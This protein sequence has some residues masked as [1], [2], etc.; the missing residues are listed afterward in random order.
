MK[1]IKRM[2]QV[3]F[4][5]YV[6]SHLLKNGIKVVLSGGASVSFYSNNAYVSHDL[7]LINV[8]FVKRQ[9]I[10]NSLGGLGFTEHGRHFIH[11][12]TKFIVEFPDGPLSV[13]EEPVKEIVEFEFSTGTLRVISATDCV[14]DRL[15]AYY[16]W[17]DNQGLA[18]AVLVAKSY[19]VDLKEIE[20]W[21]GMEGK[22]GEFREFR[23]KLK[24]VKPK[25]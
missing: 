3:E 7:D 8:D 23:K 13:G 22:A 9:R 16:F 17:N 6:Q 11:S 10:K 20:R 1:Q 12:D 4:A 14:K 19:R 25:T 15:C 18:Q 24:E 2:S 5:A 21:S